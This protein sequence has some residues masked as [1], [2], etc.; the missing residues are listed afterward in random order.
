MPLN[1][2]E[3]T[4]G[5]AQEL[6]QPRHS[7]PFYGRLVVEHEQA[8]LALHALVILGARQ[9]PH[10]DLTLNAPDAV[11]VALGTCLFE[12]NPSHFNP[13]P[14]GGSNSRV[15]FASPPRQENRDQS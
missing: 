9:I 13:F 6:D 7:A 5:K 8:G 4:G 15:A 12:N 1:Q 2:L 11:T 10:P 14:K 3:K